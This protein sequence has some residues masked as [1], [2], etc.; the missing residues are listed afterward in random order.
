MDST[1]E[2]CI[3]MRMCKTPEELALWRRAYN[4][5]NRAHAFARDFLLGRG[6]DLT[7]F[8]I[9]SAATQYA[10]DLVMADIQ[11]DGGPHTAV[12]INVAISCRTGRATAYPHPNQ[13]HHNKVRKGDA[14]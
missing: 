5:F 11:R 10:S 7:D 1:E 2:H 3:G 8:D 6:T 13:F 9:A 4:Y 14:L 12:G